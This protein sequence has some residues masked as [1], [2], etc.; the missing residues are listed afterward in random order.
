MLTL[1]S[2]RSSFGFFVRRA[3]IPSLALRTA[4]SSSCSPR[5]RADVRFDVSADVSGEDAEGAPGG[6]GGPC[7]GGGGFGRV[8]AI[9][10]H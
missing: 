8:S 1:S 3:L 7:G 5:R 6:G 2:D 10:S 9:F 4:A